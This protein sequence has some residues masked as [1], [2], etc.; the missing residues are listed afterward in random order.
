MGDPVGRRVE[1][2]GLPQ[3][4]PEGVEALV[5]LL[6]EQAPVYAGLPAAEAERLR[7]LLLLHLG[8]VGLPAS[9]MPFILEELETGLNPFPVAAAAGAFS[10]TKDAPCTAGV[11]CGG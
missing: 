11:T 1:A 5:P 10:T 7:G 4:G 8:S 9:A 3:A 6:R 2:L